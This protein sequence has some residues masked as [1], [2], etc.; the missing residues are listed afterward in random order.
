MKINDIMFVDSNKTAIKVLFED[1]SI[2]VHSWQPE[3]GNMID[4]QGWSE[5]DIE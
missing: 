2:E 3:S 5:A 1:G 4:L